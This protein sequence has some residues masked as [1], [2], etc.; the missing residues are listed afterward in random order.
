[1]AYVV[2]GIDAM[3]RS[4]HMLRWEEAGQRLLP[5]PMFNKRGEPRRFTR[6]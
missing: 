1:M 4:A 3:P 6:Y 2:T 5:P